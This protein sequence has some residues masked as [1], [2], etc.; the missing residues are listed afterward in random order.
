MTIP[1]HNHYKQKLPLACLYKLCSAFWG[2][3]PCKLSKPREGQ[4]QKASS[5]TLMTSFINHCIKNVDD[6][7]LS[8]RTQSAAMT[9]H[10]VTRQH[11]LR[12]AGGTILL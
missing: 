12:G 4:L 2:L 6:V 1:I 11:P 7:L 3:P 10:L 8:Q 9:T 5:P